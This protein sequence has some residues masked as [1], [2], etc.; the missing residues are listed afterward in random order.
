MEQYDAKS[1]HLNNPMFS[2]EQ[3][4]D[5]NYKI[6]FE[7]IDK[8]Y[9]S[10]KSGI[11]A[12]ILVASLLVWILK[13]Q[14]QNMPL[15][16]WY[17]AML[18]HTL[19]YTLLT[20]AYYRIAPPPEK[21][22]NP[23]RKYNRIASS[24]Q[25]LM[26]GC[27]SLF[28]MP[29]EPAYQFY[30]IFI[31]LAVAAVYTL[32]TSFDILLSYLVIPSILGPL[33][34]M[35]LIFGVHITE[36]LPSQNHLYQI[37]TIILVIYTIMLILIAKRSNSFLVKSIKLGYMNAKLSEKLTETNEKLKDYNQSLELRVK[38]RTEELEK[39]HKK[40]EYQ[41]N[42][43]LLTQLPNQQ[44]FDNYIQK[45][46]TGAESNNYKLA[47]LFF[48]LDGFKNINDS[49]THKAGD[50]ILITIAKRL[51]ITMESLSGAHNAVIND[52]L[53][54]RMWGDGFAIA[55]KFQSED[56]LLTTIKAIFLLMSEPF[57][58]EA[59]DYSSEAKNKTHKVTL[60]I[61]MGISKF[62]EHG[63]N[64]KVL[65]MNAETSMFHAKK[66][67]KSRYEF[68]T[69]NMNSSTLEQL[70]LINDLR[71]AIENN[72][73]VL[74]YQP[75]LDLKSGEICCVEALVR[76]QHP[77]AGLIFPN[78][79]IRLAEENGLIKALGEWVLRTACRQLKE[80]HSMGYSSLKIAVN[81]SAE[82]F[83]DDNINPNNN[84]INTIRMVLSEI[85]LDAKYLEVELTENIAFSCHERES[86]V[87]RQLQNLGLDLVIDDF[88]TGYSNLSYLSNFPISILKIDQSFIKSIHTKPDTVNIIAS[89]IEIA[90]HLRLKTVAEG[91]ETAEQKKLM[92]ELG[93]DIIQGY[94]Y[95]RPM[96][97]ENLTQF[98]AAHKRSDIAH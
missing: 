19:F 9:Q 79:F 51:N 71:H 54:A 89:I 14:V 8:R 23:W 2:A 66:K 91:I 82:Q 5:I 61:S 37:E 65:L 97:A 29:N 45:A 36:G 55:L 60:T 63:T 25:G 67:G 95:S 74:H 52:Y 80:W 7:L 32:N 12:S 72:E 43:D 11:P 73:L 83:N 94:H 20:I 70:R 28:L 44:F 64:A 6:W 78:G 35:R 33:L 68:F 81:F 49:L 31:L 40:L 75:M 87:L 46:I 16:I 50:S 90:R 39:S 92:Q 38:F 53:I 4:K 15:F 10:L 27:T 17:G 30:L 56:R 88:G 98:L 47:V 84:I 86:D 93:C 24:L 57:A 21:I 34:I 76:W 85:K 18:L 42:H 3:E 1:A 22:I 59:P 96:S 62:P 69:N 41:V 58:I 26:W 77:V 48:T 13:D